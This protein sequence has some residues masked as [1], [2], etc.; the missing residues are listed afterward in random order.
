MKVL[1][2]DLKLL[3]KILISRSGCYAHLIL[4]VG[5]RFTA[6]AD[7]CAMGHSEVS[8]HEGDAVEL[9]KV[10]C[11]GWWFIRVIGKKTYLPFGIEVARN[12][13]LN[14]CVQ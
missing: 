13:L 3:S 5:D 2:V 12:K 11:A 1:C 14:E 7:Y 6:L 8:M 10:G 4:Q 9:L